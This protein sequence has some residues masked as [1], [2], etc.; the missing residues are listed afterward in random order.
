M[1]NKD[2][3]GNSMMTYYIISYMTI[4]IIT[5]ICPGLTLNVRSSGFERRGTKSGR[6]SP[7]LRGSQ[8]LMVIVVTIIVIL[9]IVIVTRMMLNVTSS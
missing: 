2:D 5:K 4:I 8:V 7:C 1:I 6:G 3:D 9:M